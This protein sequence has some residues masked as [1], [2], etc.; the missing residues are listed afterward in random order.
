MKSISGCCRSF[1]VEVPDRR[2]A[3][4]TASAVKF[5]LEVIDQAHAK[6]INR[7]VRLIQ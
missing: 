3:G 1:V 7:D 6:T 5:P 4:Y 2:A